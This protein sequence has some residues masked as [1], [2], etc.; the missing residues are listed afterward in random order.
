MRFFE[1]PSDESW[2]Q[3]VAEILAE[4]IQVVVDEAEAFD[5]TT[6]VDC[7][8][9]PAVPGFLVCSNCAE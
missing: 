1:N 6:C 3:L 9:R 8:A 2:A 4:E 7:G 5:T